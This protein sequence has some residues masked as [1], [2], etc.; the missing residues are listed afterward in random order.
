MSKIEILAACHKESYVPQSRIIHS[1]QTG[2]AL[3][4]SR[5]NT[6]YHDD[7]GAHISEKNKYLCELTAQYWAWKNLDADYYGFFHYR[8][9]LS[10]AREYPLHAD[11]DLPCRKWR[12]YLEHKDI[13]RGLGC[14]GL[15]DDVI[16]E[17][18]KKY[19]MIT[20]LREPSNS[21]VYEQYCQFHHE[22]DLRKM[23]AI[24]EKRHPQYRAAADIYMNS[25]Q[26]YFTNMYVMKK[27][28]FFAYMEWLFPLLEEFLQKADF[29][30]YSEQECRAAAFLAE[31]LFGIYFT[32][33]KQFKKG[34]YCELQYVIF[35]NTEPWPRARR[36]FGNDSV[37]VAMA[38]CSHYVPYL[39]VL[40]QSLIECAN[41]KRDYDIIVLHTDIS[42]DNQQ[43]L[44]AMGNERFSIRFY[45]ISDYV[46]PIRFRV[47]HHFTQ[48]TFYRFF[49]MEIMRD[50]AKVLYL[51]SDMVVMRDAARLYDIEVR[52]F[53]LAAV[54]DL[55]MIG[56][57]KADADMK[58][59]V[60]R[61]LGIT[62][63]TNYF[64]GGVQLLNLKALRK[65]YSCADFV[66]MAVRRN[67]RFVDQDVMNV[68]CKGRV[69]Y[70]GQQWNVLMNWKYCGSSRMDILSQ[71]PFGLYQEYL[72]AR[73]NPAV[74][75][76]AGAWK[77]WN[78]PACDYA[79][80]FW[81]YARR[82]PFYECILYDQTAASRA[83]GGYQ[84]SMD[85]Y[86]S[87]RVFHLRPTKLKIIVDMKKINRLMPPGS[88]LR[89]VV[90]AL[91]RRFL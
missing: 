19:D 26:F 27:E 66:R 83:D 84:N 51:D 1:I 9:F 29:T 10:F 6:T 33:A 64:Q 65:R 69:K 56:Q 4:P 21:T 20:T 90:R 58:R 34:R 68:M 11:G 54:R 49:L 73:K 52:G 22:D 7:E 8:R 57:C 74:I 17:I 37:N 67:W 41:P 53:L 47:H 5:I 3:A 2:A 12:P 44:S 43:I 62:H 72:K 46:E 18:V 79:K 13:K 15:S 24:L 45:D 78:V 75:H 28:E 39:S 55:D 59:Y 81:N 31:R 71:A 38:A 23:L 61:T 80:E 88:G 48:E 63:V 40:L 70:I 25:R 86:G 82:T 30:G 42:N 85:E 35:S 89:L 36:M 87:K 91:C 32:Y 76:Y 60:Q 50:Y 14:Y 16:T 77:P